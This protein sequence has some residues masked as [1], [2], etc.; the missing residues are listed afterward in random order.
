MTGRWP[1][2][3]LTVLVLAFVVATT[4]WD[5]ETGPQEVTLAELVAE[6]EAWD[7]REVVTTGT[8]RTFDDPP[9]G[10]V[11]DE[12]GNRVELV[13]GDV[14]VEVVGR[15]VVVEG[16]FTFREGEGRR[17]DVERLVSR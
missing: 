17:I 6:Q 12:A 9:H 2:A 15:E 11:E 16:R 10:W 13:P 4:L 8:V 5:R 14:F 1:A 7:G 3:L